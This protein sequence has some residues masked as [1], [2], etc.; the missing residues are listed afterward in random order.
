MPSFLGIP[1][2]T[3]GEWMQALFA[4]FFLAV[5]IIFL[6]FVVCPW[7]EKDGNRVEVSKKTFS[8][9]RVWELEHGPTAVKNWRV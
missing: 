7:L 4:L 3:Q 1:L 6:I 2:G 9:R 8:P 5:E